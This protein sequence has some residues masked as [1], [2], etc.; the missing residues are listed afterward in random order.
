MN[1]FSIHIPSL[2][3]R[4]EDLFLYTEYF[5]DQANSALQKNILGLSPQVE[6]AFKKYN[7]PGNL[8]ELKNVIKRAVLLSPASYIPMDVIP[9]EVTA[10]KELKEPKDFSKASNEKQLILSAL[11]EANYNK[12]RAAKLLNI[13]RKTLYNKIEYY[14]LKL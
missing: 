12:S 5:L 3:E 6:A 8:R 13:T 7:W 10:A 2:A 4:K 14:N 11:E 9:L 1:E